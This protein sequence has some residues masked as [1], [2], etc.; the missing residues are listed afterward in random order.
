ML[1]YTQAK[2]GMTTFFKLGVSAKKLLHQSAIGNKIENLFSRVI[3]F[4]ENKR[5]KI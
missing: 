1:E 2:S 4:K 5:E 3:F